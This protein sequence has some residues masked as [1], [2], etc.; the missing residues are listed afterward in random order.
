MFFAVSLSLLKIF[1][2]KLHADGNVGQWNQPETAVLY[3]RRAF[4]CSM[5]G[6]EP[7]RGKIY[8]LAKNARALYTKRGRF[9]RPRLTNGGRARAEMYCSRNRLYLL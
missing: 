7:I 8:V 9:V 1:V 3:V 4:I 5:R 2:S 6:S